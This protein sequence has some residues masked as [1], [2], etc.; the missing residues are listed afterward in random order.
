MCAIPEDIL[1]TARQDCQKIVDR[2]KNMP[3]SGI[4]NAIEQMRACQII[5]MP[6]ESGEISSTCLATCPVSLLMGKQ[7]KTK[8]V[9]D[10]KFRHYFIHYRKSKNRELERFRIAHEC[11]HCYDVPPL[12]GERKL[13]PAI[14]PEVNL[15]LY[16]VKFE[17][18]DEQ[19]ADAFAS[20][21][22]NYPFSRSEEFPDVVV[23]D[24]LRSKIDRYAEQGY[25]QSTFFR[26]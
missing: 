23:D 21:L 6:I 16:V 7:E 17:L 20:I 19:Y 3:M 11:G 12:T 24:S 18:A 13:Y 22:I 14:V 15:E 4:V 8:K 26:D 25:L 1:E 9:I 5:I 10:K 2:M